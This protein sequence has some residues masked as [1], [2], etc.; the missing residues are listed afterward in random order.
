[1]LGPSS[2]LSLLLAACAAC[3]FVHEERRTFTI[4]A[5]DPGFEVPDHAALLFFVDGVDTLVLDDML[6]RG[7]LPHL[8]RH[9]VDGGVRVRRAVTGV[10]SVTFANAASMATG[11]APA[12]HQVWANTWFDRYH[13]FTR[14]Y[15]ADRDAVNADLACP[16]I[17][18]RMPRQLTSAVGAAVQRGVKLRVAVSADTGGIG[19]GLKSALGKQDLALAE[20]THAVFSLGEQARELGRWPALVLVYFNAV[21]ESG[22][23]TGPSSAGYRESLVAVDESVGALLGAFED[24]DLLGRLT[25]VLTSD[26]GHHDTPRSFALDAFLG[27]SLGVP[28]LLAEEDDEER[29]YLERFRHYSPAR[30]VVTVAGARQ[31]SL[32]L[33][34]GDDWSE[35]PTHAEILAFPR[36]AGAAS[37]DADAT[38]PQRLLAQ[39]AVHVVAVPTDDGAEVHGRRGSAAIAR[40]DDGSITYRVLAGADPL[41]HD[42]D[43]RT[44]ALLDGRA[45]TSREWLAATAGHAHPDV[46]PQLADA[47][48]TARAGDV[49]VFAAPSWDFSAEYAGG[50]GGLFAEEMLVPLFLAG[51]RIPRGAELPFA[52]LVDV[53]PTLLELGGVE[54]AAEL[55]GESLVEALGALEP[56]SGPSAADAD[57]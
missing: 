55:D 13:L 33:R 3:S 56:A 41:G 18:E 53:V 44:A 9:L 5:D 40:S 51:P 25:L 15:A 23:E 46:V 30:V 12:R 32:H 38:L 11:M 37:T 2:Q 29:E 6:A 7:E 20:M 4:D 1:M 42:L 50:H 26:H 17:F 27:E 19:V 48:G 36:A 22:H 47:F 16:T 43:E 10:P 28:V 49:L 54:G 14:D 57:D 24:A 31:A 35:R 34:T 45:R 52:R 21:D 8:Q 39:P